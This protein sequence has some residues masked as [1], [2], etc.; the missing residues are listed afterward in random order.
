MPENV[1]ADSPVKKPTKAVSSPTPV[2][3]ATMETTEEAADQGDE[4]TK[5]EFYFFSYSFQH[6]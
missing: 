1:D 3:W 6:H 4:G 5:P 2:T